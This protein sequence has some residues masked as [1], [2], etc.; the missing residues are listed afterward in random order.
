MKIEI[1]P[2][3]GRE[4]VTTLFVD[5]EAWREVH[6]SWAGRHPVFP[7]CTTFEEWEAAFD[8]FEY[9][10]VK[11]YVIWR[12]SAQPYHSQILHKLLRERHARSCTI[13]KVLSEFKALGYIN[14]EAWI[15]SYI[16]S[17]QKR[18]GFQAILAQLRAKGLSAEALQAV[19]MPEKKEDLEKEGILRLLQTRYRS[20][21]L[22]EYKTK[23]KVCASL[24]RKGFAFE[25]IKACLQDFG[26]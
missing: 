3:E 23:Q 4:G 6:T 10:R 15:A 24:M 19:E 18:F 25:N 9:K 7:A 13:E 12:L 11:G 2:K 8:Q 5:G 22:S 1:V 14:D 17:R 26:V 20:K 16:E 21:D